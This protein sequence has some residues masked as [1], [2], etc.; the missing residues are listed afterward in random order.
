MQVPVSRRV[1]S[2]LFLP[3]IPFPFCLPAIISSAQL[4]QQITFILLLIWVLGFSV[5]KIFSQ[6]LTFN[7]DQI[8]IHHR[9]KKKYIAIMYEDIQSVSRSHNI[10]TIQTIDHK[11]YASQP[12][13]LVFWKK[14]QKNFKQNHISITEKTTT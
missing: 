6:S 3:L 4:F 9:K 12:F 13:S 11:L 5:A 1:R 2:S 14:M 8:I 10:I 7:Q